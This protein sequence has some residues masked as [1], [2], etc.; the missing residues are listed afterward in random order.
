MKTIWQLKETDEEV[1]VET[2]KQLVL[3]VMQDGNMNK[4]EACGFVSGMFKNTNGLMVLIL[5]DQY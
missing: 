1:G 5:F 3:R 4:F 2:V